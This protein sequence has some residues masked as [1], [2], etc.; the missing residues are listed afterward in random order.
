MT[1]F[2]LYQPHTTNRPD[3]EEL[4]HAHFPA[5]DAQRIMLA[6]RLS[7]YGHRGQ[8]REGGDRYF[9]HPKS[10]ALMLI[11]FGVHDADI[12]IGV[13]LHDVVEDSHILVVNKS[14]DDVGFIFGSRVSHFV[15][16]MTKKKGLT[17]EQ[18]FAALL[19]DEELGSLVN[20]CADRVHN[21]STLVDSTDPAKHEKFRQKKLTQVAETREKVL[22]LAEKLAASKDFAELGAWFIFQLT[23][24]CDIREREA[25]QNKESA[26]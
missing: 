9:E 2:A 18:Y 24:W 1:H 21:L 22:P 20:K 23:S 4:V 26:A 3:F 7:K 17:T 25:A 10:I 11:E 13:L 5:H 19:A 8:M 12:I 14:V 6:Y 15:N 16:M